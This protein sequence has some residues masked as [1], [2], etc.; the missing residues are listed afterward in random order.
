MDKK[1]KNKHTEQIKEQQV[2]YEMY[3]EMPEDGQRYEI[4]DGVLE[5]MTPGPSRTHQEVNRELEFVF[6]QSCRSEFLIFFAPFDVILSETNVVQPDLLMIHRS[7][8]HIVTER[9]VEGAPD[10][11]VE[12][13]SPGSRR[14]DRIIKSGVYEEHGV[15]EYWVVDAQARTL[16]QYRLAGDSRYALINLFEDEDRVTSDKLSCVSF[17][18]GD[19]FKEIHG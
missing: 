4:I 11:V 12:I 18:L 2:T 14:R 10:L 13:L 7:R 19:I 8:K 16:E 17:V 3:A 5:L 9:G 1:N 15:P 6:M